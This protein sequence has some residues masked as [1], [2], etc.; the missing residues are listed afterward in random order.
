MRKIDIVDEHQVFK[1]TEDLNIIEEQ[2]VDVAPYNDVMKILYDM[3]QVIFKEI[4]K[5]ECINRD[6]EIRNKIA[7]QMEITGSTKDAV[8][9]KMGLTGLTK[10]QIIAKIKKEA[11]EARERIIQGFS[12]EEKPQYNQ[13][14]EQKKKIEETADRAIK[15][16]TYPEINKIRQYIDQQLLIAMGICDANLLDKDGNIHSESVIYVYLLQIFLYSFNTGNDRINTALEA[17]VGHNI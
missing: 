12:K 13:L 16:I 4:V 7:E 3:R 2:Y 9:E 17:F 1:N 15:T 11:Q 5:I 14:Y 6:M 8:I 10:D